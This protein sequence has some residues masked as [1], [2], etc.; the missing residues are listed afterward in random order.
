MK[1]MSPIGTKADI[2]T[3]SAPHV[4]G[5]PVLS[6]PRKVLVSR[7]RR[8]SAGGTH[9]TAGIYDR[10]GG[11]GII[12]YFCLGAAVGH[13]SRRLLN[14]TSSDTYAFNAEAFREGLVS[15][16]F[17]ER[18]NVLIEFPLGKRRLRTHAIPRKRIG[19]PQCGR[20]RG[21]RRRRLCARGPGGLCDQVGRS[22]LAQ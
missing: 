8:N 10:I 4:G 6:G 7:Y 17:V 9:A 20:H 1:P 16:G 22:S 3:L 5:S 15:Q 21:N 18:K 11:R 14:T 12:A 19:E 2:P 13:A